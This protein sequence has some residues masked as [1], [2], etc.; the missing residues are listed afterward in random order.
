MSIAKDHKLGQ[1]SSNIGW[2][3]SYIL[4]LV[5]SGSSNKFFADLFKKMHFVTSNMAGPKKPWRYLG[6]EVEYFLIGLPSLGAPMFGIA[7]VGDNVKLTMVIDGA[8]APE[9]PELLLERV[10]KLLTGK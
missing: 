3:L 9:N 2:Y 8:T 1:N 4:S 7:T 10:E 6:G 5:P